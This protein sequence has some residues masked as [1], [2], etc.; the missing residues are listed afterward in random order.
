MVAHA[1]VGMLAVEPAVP[2]PYWTVRARLPLWI[3]TEE[4]APVTTAAPSP[5]A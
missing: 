4:A 5:S 3:V 1:V 2:A